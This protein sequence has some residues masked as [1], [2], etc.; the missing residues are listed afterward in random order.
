MCLDVILIQQLSGTGEKKGRK[1][2][3]SVYYM[4]NKCFRERV[5]VASS[6]VQ[7]KCTLSSIGVFAPVLCIV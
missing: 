3:N 6:T 2:G 7:L 4:F 5:P 1:K